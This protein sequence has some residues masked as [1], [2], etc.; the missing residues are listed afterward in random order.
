M[1][2]TLR[3]RLIGAL[4]LVATGAVLWPLIF[5]EGPTRQISKDSI[6]PLPPSIE[7]VV[8]EPLQITNDNPAADFGPR[9]ELVFVPDDVNEEVIDPPQTLTEVDNVSS[10]IAK[11]DELAAPVINEQGL[12]EAWSVQIGAFSNQTNANNLVVKLKDAGFK[13][14]TREG[15]GVTRVLVGPK[16]SQANALQDLE[17]IRDKFQMQGRLVR[18]APE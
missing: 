9:D 6:I 15:E 5:D 4:V 16:L 14:Y 7:P 11:D 1:K 12:P 17:A 3:Q 8:I 2:Q 10:I 13:A 18:Y